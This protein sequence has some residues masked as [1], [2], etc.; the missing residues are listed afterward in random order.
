MSAPKFLLNT[1]A[2]LTGKGKPRTKKNMIDILRTHAGLRDRE[3]ESQKI[4][5]DLDG[6][7]FFPNFENAV[8]DTLL[9]ATIKDNGQYSTKQAENVARFAVA[10]MPYV[11]ND[12]LRV[13]SKDQR[14]E[15]VSLSEAPLTNIEKELLMISEYIDF[16]EGDVEDHVDF[17]TY[18][19]KQYFRAKIDEELQAVRKIDFS[20]PAKNTKIHQKPVKIANDNRPLLSRVLGG[21]AAVGALVISSLFL[22]T[23]SN[24]SEDVKFAEVEPVVSAAIDFADITDVMPAMSSPE[25][26][27]TVILQRPQWMHRLW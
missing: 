9:S 13:S 1:H 19:E 21:V 22:G 18:R 5:N 11:M 3:R 12:I 16:G 2:L 4:L 8:K 23:L 24:V 6:N 7:I 14:S 17:A 26:S 20:E 10:Y 27:T 25:V 15:A